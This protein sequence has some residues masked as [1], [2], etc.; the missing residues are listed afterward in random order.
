DRETAGVVVFTVNPQTRGRYQSLFA[1]REVRK[2]YEAVAPLNRQLAFPLSVALRIEAD[3]HFMRMR[4]ADGEPNS[5]TT[6]DLMRSH[7]ELGRFRLTAETGKK[8]QLRVVMA[9]LGM[10]IRNDAIYPELRGPADYSHPLQLL[11]REVAFT[12]PLTGEARR[13]RSRRSLAM[14]P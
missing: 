5:L 3:R 8:H 13:F 7:G 1:S 4:V 12:D 14:V 10:P 11:A 9:W 2:E 6:I